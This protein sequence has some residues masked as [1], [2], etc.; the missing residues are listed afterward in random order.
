M[1]NTKTRKGYYRTFLNKKKGLASVEY[2][3]TKWNTEAVEACFTI[4]DCTRTITLDFN[5]NGK[6]DLK[7]RLDKVDKLIESLEKFKQEVLID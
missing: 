4:R 5:I 6:Q 2:G 3:F 1:V 7:D